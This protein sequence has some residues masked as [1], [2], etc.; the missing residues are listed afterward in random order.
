MRYPTKEERVQINKNKCP[1]CKSPKHETEF[2]KTSLEVICLSCD[3]AWTI[4]AKDG[5]DEIII[6]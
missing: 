1:I 4:Y 2:G 5:K 6:W 3:A